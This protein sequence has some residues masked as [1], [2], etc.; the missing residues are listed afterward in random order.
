MLHVKLYV[1]SGKTFVL[2]K[3]PES[4]YTTMHLL[5]TLHC[6]VYS[7][8][9]R[10]SDTHYPKGSKAK[11]YAIPYR[12]NIIHLCLHSDA[13]TAIYIGQLHWGKPFALIGV[14]PSGRSLPVHSQLN[15]GGGVSGGAPCG[16]HGANT[17][18]EWKTTRSVTRETVMSHTAQFHSAV[19]V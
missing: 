17:S 14:H 15:Y 18:L 6:P 5:C 1:E 19:P 13:L 3:K 4:I 11:H 9:S 12:T 10:A 16:V 7:R 2:F 8:D